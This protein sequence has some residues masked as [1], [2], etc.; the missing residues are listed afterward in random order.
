MTGEWDRSAL[1]SSNPFPKAKGDHWSTGL[2]HCCWEGP[3]FLASLA[4]TKLL[5]GGGCYWIQPESLSDDF[6][7]GGIPGPMPDLGPA[8]L[9]THHL[10]PFPD[11]LGGLKSMQPRLLEQ[12]I[13][14]R[15]P[16]AMTPPA[17]LASRAPRACCPLMNCSRGPSLVLLGPSPMRCR[18]HFE[19]DN[20]CPAPRASIDSHDHPCR[21]TRV[22]CSRG[23][24]TATSNRRD[25]TDHGRLT[26]SF[27]SITHAQ[28]PAIFAWTGGAKP[29][30]FRQQH[31]TRGTKQPPAAAR[32]VRPCCAWGNR[33]GWTTRP[34]GRR[35]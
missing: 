32:G 30:R 21:A 33:L 9:F 16:L 22:G 20:P 2:D 35:T 15:L 23:Q 18:Q 17:G 8:W 4:A 28:V 34:G 24:R 19:T 6:T 11:R 7:G 13:A 12:G 25:E 14:S 31:R 29:P 27:A 26:F 3:A 1:S 10:G 5:G